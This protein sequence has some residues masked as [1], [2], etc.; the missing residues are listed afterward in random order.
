MRKI[1]I[2]IPCSLAFL[3]VV[4]IAG[5]GQETVT[6]P[7]VVSTIPANGAT[8][9][10]IN[11]AIS[12]TFSMAMNPSTI[13]ASSFTVTGPGGAAVAG[14]V[15][16]SGLTA[17]FA[18]DAPLAYNAVYTATIT[19]GAT[20]MGGTPLLANYVWS[21]TTNMPPPAVKSTNPLNGALSVPISQVL[22]A[23]FSE[24]MAPSTISAST[25]TL[26]GPGG[27]AVAGTVAYS[28]VIAKFTPS[29][30]L[31]NGTV[32][33]ATITTGATNVAG[34]PLPTNYAWTFTTI[35]P[36]PTVIAVVPANGA[37]GV[38][39]GQV[40]TATFSEAM[41]CATLTSTTFTLTGPGASA[42]AG[43]V[44]CAGSVA[45]LIPAAQLAANTLGTPTA[46][47]SVI[48]I[49]GAKA[50]NVY[51]AVGGLPGAV[52]N[53]GGGGTMVGTIISQP[54]ITVSSPGVATVT[55]INGRVLALSASTTL[56]NTVINVP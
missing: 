23:T 37:T 1:R 19:T 3:W 6:V 25:F 10:S 49:N 54:G 20:E 30:S 47:E 39:L 22:S 56:V 24:A 29:A 32:Y 13:T 8:A 5:C 27:A 4:F 12:A 15:T 50:S 31:A 42:V 18:S 41:N 35:A 16:Y 40:L 55:T 28:G 36:A 9:V 53:Y 38:P 46:P 52:I 45:T 34:T 44:S 2:G 26:T 33:T 11:T 7:S 43:T 48:M 17:T 14:A 21:F 51:W